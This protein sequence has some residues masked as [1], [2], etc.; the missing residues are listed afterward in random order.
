[1]VLQTSSKRDIQFSPLSVQA[2]VTELSA[3]TSSNRTA[4]GSTDFVPT[5][6]AEVSLP[7]RVIVGNKPITGFLQSCRWEQEESV[8]TDNRCNQNKHLEFLLSNTH[9]QPINLSHLVRRVWRWSLA[10]S[11]AALHCWLSF[12]TGRPIYWCQTRGQRSRKLHGTLQMIRNWMNW[13]T[14]LQ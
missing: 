1:M 6:L 3:I 12:W 13:I 8:K 14:T 5:C 4:H 2:G 7:G 11:G 10:G 9:T